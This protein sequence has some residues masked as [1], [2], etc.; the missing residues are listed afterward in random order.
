[1]RGV[2]FDF[3]GTLFFDNDKHI[4]AWNAISEKLRNRPITEEELHQRLNGVPNHEIIQYF[5]NGQ[6]T[7]EDL[8][9]YSLL[10]ESYYR[11][12]CWEDR[13]HFHLVD[14][15][16]DYFEK[17]KKAEIPFTIASASI[18]ENIDFF[19]SSFDL[20]AWVDPSLLVYDDGRFKNKVAMFWQA[21]QNIKVP[22]EETLVFE[23]SFSGI[24]NAYEAG[25]K[26]IVAVCPN[27][28]AKIYLELP[29]VVS[30]IEDFRSIS[31]K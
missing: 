23:D 11:R 10:K 2:I 19:R 15:V 14:G 6:A 17:L 27:K 5:M 4:K 1:M 8:E 7:E 18:K 3:N 20:D 13:D 26:E 31:R 29:G 24:K 28:K 16:L 12:F 25:V 30:T 9:T 22:I 21:A